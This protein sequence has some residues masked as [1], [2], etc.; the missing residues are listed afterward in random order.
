MSETTKPQ[1]NS[2]FGVLRCGFAKYPCLQTTTVLSIRELSPGFYLAFG[3]RAQ[4]FYEV[5]VGEAGG[6]IS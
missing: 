6:R 1:A 4:D 2:V 3:Y 5:I